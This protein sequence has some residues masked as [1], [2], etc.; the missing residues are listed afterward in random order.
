[1][2]AQ[3]LLAIGADPSIA[4]KEGINAV[5]AAASEGHKDIVELLLKSS[6][7]VNAQ[8]KVIA[9]LVVVVVVVV[10]R[11]CINGQFICRM[12]PTR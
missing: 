12:V 4:N 3:A 7:D 8:D 2:V 11:I 6:V 5:I 10:V 9:Q 1:M